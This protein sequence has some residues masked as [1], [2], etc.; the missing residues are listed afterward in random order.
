M[1]IRPATAN[2][3]DTIR[4]LGT[5]THPAADYA[6]L[7]DET[8]VRV[9]TQNNAIVGFLVLVDGT[10]HLLIEAAS[11]DPAHAGKGF[12]KAMAMFAEHEARNRGYDLVRVNADGSNA[13]AVAVYRSLGFRE[14]QPDGT[15]GRGPATLEKV[16]L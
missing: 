10:D 5:R 16:V 9:L 4:A 8:D 7:I 13:A 1:A 3:V 11:V 6:A 15:G 2:D 12:E 14:T